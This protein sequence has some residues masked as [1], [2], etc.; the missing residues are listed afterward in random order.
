MTEDKKPSLL[1]V[2]HTYATAFNRR[3]LNPL[4]DYFDITCV[5]WRLDGGMLYGRPLSDYEQEDHI[6]RYT[7]VRLPV[8]F[9]DAGSTRFLMPGLAAVIR[10]R[11]FDVVLADSEPWGFVRW[12]T[13]IACALFQRAAMF[14]EFSWENIERPGLK[15][16]FLSA[17]YKL[18]MKTAHFTISGNAACRRIL[19]HHGA[20]PDSNL[21]A[22]QLGVEAEEFKPADAAEKREL[23][24]A[25]GLPDDGFLIGF[26]GRYTE[27]KGIHELLEAVDLLRKRLPSLT[28]RLAMLGHGE[29]GKELAAR[30]AED[31]GLHLLSP[32][33]HKEVA[34]FMRG[35]DLFILPSKPQLTGPDMWEEQ[36][37]H[38]LIEAMAAGVLTLGSSSGAIPE[39]IDFPEAIFPHS[40]APAL[41]RCMEKWVADDEG[42]A[43][44]AERQYQRTIDQYTHEALGQVWGEFITKRLEIHRN[45]LLVPSSGRK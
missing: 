31:P 2:G 32:R 36:F 27:S 38:V 7:L 34:S 8:L 12:Q 9:R 19:L 26:C 44:L 6:P 45:G 14:G 39:V 16:L 37:G 3:K 28:I 25:L 5:T 40:D 17:A 21:V 1:L 35:L 30:A 33:P 20:E 11:Q 42:R 4:A 29:M 23:R 43:A 41:A 13:W 24:K 18:A 10:G 22:G 15:G